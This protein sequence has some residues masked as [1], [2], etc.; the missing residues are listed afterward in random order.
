MMR[1]SEVKR[2]FG[3]PKLRWDGNIR[4]DLSR[5][6]IGGVNWVSTGASGEHWQ[7]RL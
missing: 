4:L 7:T 1:K 2:T 3:K 6:R 5:N